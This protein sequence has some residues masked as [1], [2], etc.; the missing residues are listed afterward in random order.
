[1]SEVHHGVALLRQRQRAIERRPRGPR[2][3][4]LLAGARPEQDLSRL[5]QLVPRGCDSG[6]EGLQ[7]VEWLRSLFSSMPHRLI[8]FHPQQRSRCGSPAVAVH[9]GGSLHPPDRVIAK[10]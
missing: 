1:M 10:R 7:A 9:R 5:L 3:W 6:E 2:G 8:R 4:V